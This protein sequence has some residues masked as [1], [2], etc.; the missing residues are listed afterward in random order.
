MVFAIVIGL[1]ALVCL[2][3]EFFMPGGVLALCA[4]FLGL[5]SA[6][7]FFWQTSALW[8]GGVYLL[9]L[10]VASVGIC[11]LAIKIL[12]RSKDSFCLH[13]DQEGFTSPSVEEDL[14]GKEG[15]VATEL[16]P[17]GHVRIDGKIYQAVSQKDFLVKDCPIEVVSI[18]GSRLIVKRKI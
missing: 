17:A 3:L 15:F 9:F 8:M 10:L 1:I 18:E 13:N 4:A 16:K 14:K 6:G 5:I 7:L 12:K 2:Y 11:F